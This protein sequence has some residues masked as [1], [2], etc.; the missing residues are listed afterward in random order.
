MRAAKSALALSNYVIIERFLRACWCCTL[1]V[2]T[3]RAV[4][5]CCFD[6]P[7]SSF[8][9]LM[10]IH[11]GPARRFFLMV[12]AG[13]V[14]LACSPKYDW[15]EIHGSNAPFSA[16]MPGKTSEYT[17]PVL[18]G[19]FK[20]DMTMTATQV[21]GASY[22]IGTAL[23]ADEA[24]AHAA[25]G[26]MKEALVK[27][28]DGKIS[29]EHGE[30]KPYSYLQIEAEGHQQLYGGGKKVLLFARFVAYEKRIYQVVVAGDDTPAMRQAADT[31]LSSFKP[32]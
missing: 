4:L 25:L 2:L 6:C 23:L 20:A 21:D 30:Q 10:F 11:N 8:S 22:A 12:A 31:F 27:N 3:W 17:R 1:R 19:K 5:A 9:L 26:Y 24:S 15:R 29:H 32:N 14:L 18:L 13:L 16:T 28:I 7:H